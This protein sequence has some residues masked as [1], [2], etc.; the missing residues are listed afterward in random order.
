MK[1]AYI[2]STRRGVF[3]T[4]AARIKPMGKTFEAEA[5][6]PAH[7]QVKEKPF[8]PR[9]QQ[10]SSNFASTSYR[11]QDPGD[12]VKVSN[13]TGVVI[14]TAET[15]NQSQT[16]GVK[17]DVSLSRSLKNVFWVPGSLTISFSLGC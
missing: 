5:P 1:R 13:S 10:M 2:E 7:Y 12:P 4:T 11:I 9:Y 14:W 8:A 6:G 15:V 17:L 3:G 16:L